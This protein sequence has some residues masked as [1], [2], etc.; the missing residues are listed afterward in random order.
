MNYNFLLEFQ[1]YTSLIDNSQE[2][3]FVTDSIRALPTSDIIK[4]FSVVPRAR[5]ELLWRIAQPIMAF[6]LMFLAVPLGFVNPR[7]GRSFNLIVAL[8]LYVA[9]NN[10]TSVFQ[11]SVSRGRISFMLGWWPLHLLVALIIVG[12]YAW[13]LCANSPY[14]PIILLNNWRKKR[15]EKEG[16]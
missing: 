5:G 14:H 3:E 13:R 10:F 12:L 1:K 2:T 4:K 11:S 9:Y 15:R 7:A 6:L 16:K 8:L